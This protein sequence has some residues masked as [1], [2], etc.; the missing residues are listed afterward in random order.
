MTRN[1]ARSIAFLAIVATGAVLAQTKPDFSG[2]WVAVSGSK[3]AIGEETLIKQDAT[4]RLIVSMDGRP[5]SRTSRTAPRPIP[6]KR[7]GTGRRS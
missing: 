7:C 5:G 4:S 2:T 3:E 1:L 6:L